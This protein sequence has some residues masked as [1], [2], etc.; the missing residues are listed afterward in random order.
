MKCIKENLTYQH[1]PLND[2][3][4]LCAYLQ[5]GFYSFENQQLVQYEKTAQN[6]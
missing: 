2:C 3:T 5:G 4:D 1:M 6:S